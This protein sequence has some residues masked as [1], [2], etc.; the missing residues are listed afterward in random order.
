MEKEI[1]QW[2]SYILLQR[3]HSS[4]GSNGVFER[5]LETERRNNLSA[6]G[7]GVPERLVDLSEFGRVIDGHGQISPLMIHQQ[8][9]PNGDTFG[10]NC[11]SRHMPF[12]ILLFVHYMC[13][14]KCSEIRPTK[15]IRIFGKSARSTGSWSARSDRKCGSLY[16]LRGDHVIKALQS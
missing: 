5:S 14:V 8:M 4:N 11:L 7:R 3:S 16:S 13:K 12:S 10:E 15:E 2:P 1:D 9:E 6:A